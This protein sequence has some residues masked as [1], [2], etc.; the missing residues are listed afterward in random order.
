MSAGGRNLSPGR[1]LTRP[2]FIRTTT[3]FDCGYGDEAYPG[4]GQAGGYGSAGAPSGYG[5]SECKRS[6]STQCYNTPRV[7]NTEKCVPKD[8][9]VSAP[10]SPP[11]RRLKDV[12]PFLF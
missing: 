9:Q 4:S 7:V 8:T 1:P 11:S 5:A 6:Y 3:K 2:L 12:V 10:R